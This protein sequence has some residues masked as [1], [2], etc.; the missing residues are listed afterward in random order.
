MSNAYKKQDLEQGTDQWHSLRAPN[1]NASAASIFAPN[2]NPYLTAI[3]YA[4]EKINGT[5]QSNKGKERIFEIGHQV[6]TQGRKY[7]NESLGF[8][9]IPTVV[10][11]NR[12]DRLLASLD[13]MDEQK[14]IVLETKFTGAEN[15]AKI[16]KG[17]VPEHHIYQ[18][19]AQLL[20]TGFDRCLY[21]A[22]HKEHFVTV[23]IRPDVKIQK[24]LAEMIP[25]FMEACDRGELPEPSD[26]DFHEP[27]DPRFDELIMLK[28]KMD[29]IN[30]Q[31]D[32]LKAALAKD[33]AL[34]NRVRYRDLTM[35][36]S[37]TKGSINYSK[38]P[39]LKEMDLEKYRGASR[40]S[41]TVRI[42]KAK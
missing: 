38:I 22:T 18:V 33:F 12:V 23:D 7:A 40:S 16:G 39:E 25:A 17:E 15:L 9:F 20:A 11:S 30:D 2:G 19:Q 29:L 5:K 1:F 4:E 42:G 32:D 13:G 34:Y 31:F 24:Q 36:R 14:G 26:R 27:N 3:Q 35:I 28:N 37:V 8:N 41:V 21:M 6:E 10:L